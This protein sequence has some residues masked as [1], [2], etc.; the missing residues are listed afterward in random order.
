M[1]GHHAFG[2]RECRPGQQPSFPALSER[3]QFASSTDTPTTP[4]KCQFEGSFAMLPSMAN[5]A[6]LRIISSIYETLQRKTRS[7]RR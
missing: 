2:A 3:A 5:D 4:E 1:L 6:P 7:W